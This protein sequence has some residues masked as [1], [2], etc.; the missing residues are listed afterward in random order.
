MVPPPRRTSAL[1]A[2]S[3]RPA[4]HSRSCRTGCCLWARCV[5]GVRIAGDQTRVPLLLST[6]GW[7]SLEVRGGLPLQERVSLQ[8]AAAN[9]LDRNYR[10]HGSGVDAPGFNA[11]VGVRYRF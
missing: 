9:L 4:R 6:A 10:L 5:N 1:T 8:F 2:C 11:Y 7:Y 3:S